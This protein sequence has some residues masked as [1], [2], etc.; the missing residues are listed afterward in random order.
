MVCL[1]SFFFAK[2]LRGY[3]FEIYKVNYPL[4]IIHYPLSIIHY[5]LSIIH[6][7]KEAATHVTMNSRFI[8]ISLSKY[9]S[10]SRYFN[11]V[12]FRIY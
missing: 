6:Y 11:T 7:K 3:V 4:S 2:I 9:H 1:P 8:N 10:I 5:P 12:L